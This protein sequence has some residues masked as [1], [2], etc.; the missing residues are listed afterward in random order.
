M[1]YPLSELGV[2]MPGDNGITVRGKT[3][4]FDMLPITIKMEGK[5]ATKYRE[6]IS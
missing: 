4:S 6:I 5:H 3:Y 1:Q 2:V